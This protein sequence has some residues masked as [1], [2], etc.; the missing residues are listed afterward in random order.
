MNK[1]FILDV[2]TPRYSFEIQVIDSFS[3][4]TFNRLM[5]NNVMVITHSSDNERILQETIDIKNLTYNEFV[6]IC[7][8]YLNV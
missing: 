4:D 8:S 5:K 1:I 6:T 7:R 2:Y 3:E